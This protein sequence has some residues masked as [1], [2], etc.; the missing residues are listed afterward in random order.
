MQQIDERR[1]RCQEMER[2]VDKLSF[3]RGELHEKERGFLDMIQRQKQLLIEKEEVSVEIAKQGR[4]SVWG[5]GVCKGFVGAISFIF[6]TSRYHH[7]LSL[8]VNHLTREKEHLIKEK[9]NLEMSNREAKSIN[10]RLQAKLSKASYESHRREAELQLLVVSL[11]EKLDQVK[12]ESQRREERFAHF[13]A[14]QSAQMASM[15]GMLQKQ[16]EGLSNCTE[17]LQG[18]EDEIRKKTMEITDKSEMLA[19]LERDMLSLAAQCQKLQSE[20]K[21]K[22][23]DLDEIKRNIS[24]N[25]LKRLDSILPF[26]NHDNSQSEDFRRGNETRVLE[27]LANESGDPFVHSLCTARNLTTESKVNK[28]EKCTFYHVNFPCILL[29][30]Q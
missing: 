21:E 12:N 13:E 29:V 4:Q 6:S 26:L 25:A 19:T 8:P 9:E 1:K 10:E 2:K 3:K 27:A 28:T 16:D 18:K 5:E 20:L 17:I 14:V 15:K 22:T 24:R 30:D 7:L 23:Q 11:Q